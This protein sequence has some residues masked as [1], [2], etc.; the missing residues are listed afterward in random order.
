LNKAQT[1]KL[2]QARAFIEQDQPEMAEPLLVEL[3]DKGVKTFPVVIE[4]VLC[5]LMLGEDGQA[6]Q[7]LSLAE[8]LSPRHSRVCCY[9]GYFMLQER[10]HDTALELFNAAL[11]A[12]PKNVDAYKWR[13][14]CYHELDDFARA[15]ADFDR[16]VLHRRNDPML[17]AQRAEVYYSMGDDERATEELRQ[18]L[19]VAPDYAQAHALLGAIFVN[20]DRFEEAR[21]A[22]ERAIE[23]DFTAVAA[24]HDLYTMYLRKGEF[25]LALRALA[26]ALAI[27]PED[28]ETHLDMALLLLQLAEFELVPYHLDRAKN[29][30]QRQ[31]M[32]LSARAFLAMHSEQAEKAVDLFDAALALEPQQSFA[33]THAPI[34]RFCVHGDPQ[35]LAKELESVRDTV[36][37]PIPPLVLSTA[38]ML[39]QELRPMLLQFSLLSLTGNALPSILPTDIEALVAKLEAT[40]GLDEPPPKKRKARKKPQT[41]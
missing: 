10:R 4:L 14:Q 21:D 13:G 33:N 3:F 2:E 31:S 17:Y 18:A 22:L 38:S 5:Y 8:A 37:F 11:T 34:A 26:T 40:E 15:L 29:V 9:R 28:D 24:W 36:E 7:H 20:Q 39:G 1:R 41:S 19:H 12:D 27:A 6:K 16:A 25:P 32:V 35:R 23:L 30:G